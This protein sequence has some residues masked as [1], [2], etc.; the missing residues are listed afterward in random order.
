M[1][2]IAGAGRMKAIDLLLEKISTIGLLNTI[3]WASLRALD[4]LFHINVIAITERSIVDAARSPRPQS[5]AMN[6]FL[7]ADQMEELTGAAYEFVREEKFSDID[8]THQTIRE[9]LTSH[10]A[11]CI[12]LVDDKI[13]AWKWV[14]YTQMIVP[15]ISLQLQLPANHV[16]IF[17]VYTVPSYRGKKIQPAAASYLFRQLQTEG[18]TDCVGYACIDNPSSIATQKSSGWR[19]RGY[20]L[21]FKRKPLYY[22][23]RL[24]HD[25]QFRDAMSGLKR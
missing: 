22:S 23:R 20:I 8:H 4:R 18:I 3:Q 7:H 1:P 13:V 17:D 11:L 10:R 5:P 9:R 21:T 24:H 15:E 16:H 6:K 12:S 2:L 19:T 14:D 25:I